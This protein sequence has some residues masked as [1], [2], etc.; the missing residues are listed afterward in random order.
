MYKVIYKKKRNSPQ[1]IILNQEN[2][3][4]AVTPLYVA[5]FADLWFE[6]GWESS[7][8]IV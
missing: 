1:K 3:K 2:K 4:D 7:V 5:G 6:H 8:S